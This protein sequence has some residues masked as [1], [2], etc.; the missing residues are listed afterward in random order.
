MI[1]GLSAPRSLEMIVVILGILKAGGAYLPLDPGYPRERLAFMIED[2]WTSASAAIFLHSRPSALSSRRPARC[3][4]RRA[5]RAAWAP[6]A[7]WC[8]ISQER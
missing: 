6:A 8:A 3:A 7:V 2:A 4:S 1:V 5:V